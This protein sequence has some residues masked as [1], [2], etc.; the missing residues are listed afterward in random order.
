MKFREN[1]PLSE[2]RQHWLNHDI[3]AA[4]ADIE[5]LVAVGGANYYVGGVGD[6]LVHY[7]LA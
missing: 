4:D 2:H 1:S 5:V 6:E 7:R 3:V